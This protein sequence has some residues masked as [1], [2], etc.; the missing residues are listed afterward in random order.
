MLW[1]LALGDGLYASALLGALVELP[2]Y[3]I[4]TPLGDALGRPR[5]WAAFLFATSASL[6]ALGLA[7]ASSTVAPALML[8]ARFGGGGAS[9]ICYVAAAEAFPTSCR[10]LG[11]GYGACCGRVGS[12]LAPLLLHLAP[13]PSIIFG[14]LGVGC[15]AVVLAL[16]DTTGQ[17]IAE[18]AAYG[19]CDETTGAHVG[20]RHAVGRGALGSGRSEGPAMTPDAEQRSIQ[21]TLLAGSTSSSSS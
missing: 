18:S 16:P 21:L 20:D 7:G 12:M 2:A 14:A 13:A 15:C 10:S 19:P 3:A 5:A 17:P 11:V 9:T 1:P 8:L 6:I 4:M